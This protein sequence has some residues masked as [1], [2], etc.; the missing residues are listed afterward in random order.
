MSKINFMWN[1]F[2]RDQARNL[3]ITVHEYEMLVEERGR[4]CR[5][6]RLKRM[7]AAMDRKNAAER[8][9]YYRKTAAKEGISYEDVVKRV[10]LKH[11]MA[12]VKDA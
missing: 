4:K 8:E 10:N 12:M 7:L 6:E 2:K 1:A 11:F 5:E 3:G 9:R